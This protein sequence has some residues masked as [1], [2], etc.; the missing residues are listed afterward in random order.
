MGLI[1][2]G[3]RVQHAQRAP[4]RPLRVVLVHRRDPEHGHD[5]VPDQLVQGATDALDLGAQPGVER[6][7]HGPDVFGSCPARSSS[8]GP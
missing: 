2:L 6:A 7:Q 8:T 3:D 1:E 4:H 5:R